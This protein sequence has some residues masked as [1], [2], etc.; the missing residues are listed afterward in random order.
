MHSTNPQPPTKSV[1]G[2]TYSSLCCDALRAT[3]VTHPAD[4]TNKQTRKSRNLETWL[5]PFF[6]RKF[7]NKSEI[8]RKKCEVQ[9][10]C[11]VTQLGNCFFHTI[12]WGKFYTGLK[13]LTQFSVVMVVTNM[14]PPNQTMF[15]ALCLLKYVF[16]HKWDCLFTNEIVFNNGHTLS[17]P[18]KT[19]MCFKSPLL[20][21]WKGFCPI[22]SWVMRHICLHSCW[23]VFL[24]RFKKIGQNW[25]C[26]LVNSPH[27]C[28]VDWWDTSAFSAA[29]DEDWLFLLTF[30]HKKW[31]WRSWTWEESKFKRVVRWFFISR[32]FLSALKLD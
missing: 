17:P 5:P 15:F 21:I 20:M 32:K 3:H 27:P 8:F 6:Q 23:W 29:K 13:I 10:K 28:W 31:P 22:F 16:K 25:F 18:N 14:P 19:L 7:R 30:C 24:L 9:K 2:C 12:P 11:K 1:V 4:A 26:H